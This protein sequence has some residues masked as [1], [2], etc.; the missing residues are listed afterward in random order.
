MSELQSI[1]LSKDEIVAEV[2]RRLDEKGLLST[3]DRDQYLRNREKRLADGKAYR[4]TR[5]EQYRDYQRRWRSENPELNRERQRLSSARKLEKEAGR[6]KP[7]KCE[8]CGSDTNLCF[9]HCH[10]SGKFRGWICS[11]C[12]KVLGFVED[13]PEILYSLAEYLREQD[14]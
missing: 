2:R 12:N 3:Y 11:R 7:D 4:A 5:H 14:R 8:I 1:V 13:D 6:P 10:V 9:D